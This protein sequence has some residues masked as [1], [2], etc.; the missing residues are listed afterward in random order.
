MYTSCQRESSRAAALRLLLL[1]CRN[2]QRLRRESRV[3]ER[4]EREKQNKGE[5]ERRE[6]A[7]EGGK[8]KGGGK[9]VPPQTS[10]YAA[11]RPGKLTNDEGENSTYTYNKG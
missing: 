4:K 11:R 1:W 6:E 7:P 9:K 10:D 5:W 3:K 2:Y 8:K